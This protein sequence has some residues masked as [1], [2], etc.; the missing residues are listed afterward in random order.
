MMEDLEM[1]RAAR[2]SK[3]EPRR[4]MKGCEFEGKA[5]ESLECHTL[6]AAGMLRSAQY[7]SFRIF[8]SFFLSACM[9]PSVCRPRHSILSMPK[10]EPSFQR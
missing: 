7:D 4:P 5:A 2:E 10:I 9:R 1:G 6:P 8:H 3:G